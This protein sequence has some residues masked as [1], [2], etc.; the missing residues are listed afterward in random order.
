MALMTRNYR[1]A[2]RSEK[3][4]DVPA[5]NPDGST[6]VSGKD[7]NRHGGRH[8]SGSNP[9][10]PEKSTVRNKRSG[11]ARP[12]GNM[13]SGL[14]RHTTGKVGF[15]MASLLTE[16]PLVVGEDMAAHTQPDRLVFPKGSRMG[17]TLHIRVEGPF[18]MEMQHLEH[19]VV[20]R[21][22]GHFGYGIVK[23]IRLIQAP[24]RKRTARRTPPAQKP[25]P[26]DEKELAALKKRL[27]SVEDPGIRA[28]LE[29]IG[30]QVLR[31]NSATLI[32]KK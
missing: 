6:Q 32:D 23:A 13:V 20:E 5:T 14:T 21:I 1:Y 17:G 31:R 26:A 11:Y 28:V 25:P 19:V 24:L 7:G 22:N 3:H 10:N 4:V 12:V 15:A 16:W 9:D 30:E 8:G 18:A 27:E 2:G 29:R